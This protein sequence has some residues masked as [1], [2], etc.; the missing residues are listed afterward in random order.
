VPAEEAKAA[1][2]EVE[3]MVQA[4]TKT[5]KETKAKWKSESKQNAALK[6]QISHLK[7]DIKEARAVQEELDEEAQ[8]VKEEAEEE[9]QAKIEV[10]KKTEAKLKKESKHN[11]ALDAK[12]E[13]LKGSISDAQAKQNALEEEARLAKEE[14]EA[15]I[16]AQTKA[17]NEM[18]VNWS[19]E[20]IARLKRDIAN[21]KAEQRALDVSRAEAAE[22]ARQ[23]R[24]EAEEKHR[25]Q[26]PGRGAPADGGALGPLLE[27]GRS[28]PVAF[29]S[30]SRTL[31]SA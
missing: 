23:T 4:Q 14:A 13:Q 7:E 15:K 28:C 29:V 24:K 27:G 11:S 6:S 9:I 20:A 16:E 2:E 26:G 21:A 18:Q 30:G 17:L 31:L 25:A 22:E 19:T 5:M 8:R 12:I 3:S 1:K 10:L